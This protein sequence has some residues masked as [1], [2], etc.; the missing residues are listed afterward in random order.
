MFL[1]R[2]LCWEMNESVI[3]ANFSTLNSFFLIHM[4]TSWHG[5]PFGKVIFM[6][7]PQSLTVNNRYFFAAH[8]LLKHAT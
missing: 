6:S 3:K 2:T 8:I 5:P 1:R 7:S 4:R